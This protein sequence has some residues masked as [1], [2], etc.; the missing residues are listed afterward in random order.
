[1]HP[2]VTAY[3]W[4]FNQEEKALETRKTMNHMIHMEATPTHAL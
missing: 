4:G 2:S 1:M 3:V